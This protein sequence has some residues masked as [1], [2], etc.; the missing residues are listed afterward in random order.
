MNPKIL[1]R[2]NNFLSYELTENIN[3]V[4]KANLIDFNL[5]KYNSDI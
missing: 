4:V 1:I 5:M 2:F 3:A